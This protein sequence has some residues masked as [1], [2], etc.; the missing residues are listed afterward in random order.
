MDRFHINSEST[1][2]GESEYTVFDKFESKNFRIRYRFALNDYLERHYNG[3]AEQYQRDVVAS[4]YIVHKLVSSEPID[5]AV[6]EA[7]K[8]YL[9]D[10]WLQYLEHCEQ[11][12]MQ[13]KGDP[14]I[15]KIYL[16]G[17]ACPIV[18]PGYWDCGW[19]VLKY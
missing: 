15:E 2:Q 19:H 18:K 13:F 3:S 6:F 17:P 16:A 7:F 10:Q 1:Y 5:K 14:E 8:K 12:K 11:R 4:L 9:E